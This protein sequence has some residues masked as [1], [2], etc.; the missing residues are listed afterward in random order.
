MPKISE[1]LKILFFSWYSLVILLQLSWMMNLIYVKLLTGTVAGGREE[2]N[3]FQFL[4]KMFDFSLASGGN[5]CEAELVEVPE[6]LTCSVGGWRSLWSPKPWEFGFGIAVW[7]LRVPTMRTN[8]G[9]A[10]TARLLWE[11]RII[12]QHELMPDLAGVGNTERII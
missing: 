9:Q 11:T 4:Y 3:V 5:K 2:K 12:P 8:Q 7:L 10:S 6:H 1:K